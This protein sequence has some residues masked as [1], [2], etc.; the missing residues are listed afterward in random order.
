MKLFQI[1]PEYHSK[2]PLVRKLFFKR[3]EAAIQLAEIKKDSCQKVID[4]GCGEGLFLK[5]L[6]ERFAKLNIFGIDNEPKV[7]NIKKIIGVD[8]EVGDLRNSGF[9]SNFFDIVFCL[10]VLEH[11]TNL[12]A[13]VNEIKK[14]LKPDGL[15]VVSLPTENTFYK[16]GRLIIKGTMSE[17]K[18]PCSSPH[19]YNAK[20]IDNFLCHNGFKIVRKT[21]LPSR[22]FPLFEIS[23]FSFTIK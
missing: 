23:S 18:G 5:L 7:K 19:F 20:K 15:L 6:Q 2:N 13:P 9:P 8:I 21:F 22:F 3:F 17:R 16:I 4:L 12:E 14:I 10:D 11:F 1:V